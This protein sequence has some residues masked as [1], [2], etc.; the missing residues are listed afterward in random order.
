MPKV[1]IPNEI[2]LTDT[3]FVRKEQRKK[4]C[5]R[6]AK[7]CVFRRTS[8]YGEAPQKASPFY[9]FLCLKIGKSLTDG[10]VRVSPMGRWD[11][12]RFWGVK[13]SVFEDK[14]WRDFKDIG[15]GFF[16]STKR[17]FHAHDIKLKRKRL[18]MWW[19][20]HIF[21]RKSQRIWKNVVS[22]YCYW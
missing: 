16:L 19:G 21:V 1:H 9:V 15:R 11:S 3:L 14:E 20:C 5:N 13:R 8:T 12:H 17:P 18:Q 7:R 4:F 10:E 22:S 6:I 2:N